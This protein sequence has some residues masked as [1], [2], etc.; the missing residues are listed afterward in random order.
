MHQAFFHS[1][2][3]REKVR[4]VPVF[5][6][7]KSFFVEICRLSDRERKM[8]KNDQNQSGFQVSSNAFKENLKQTFLKCKKKCT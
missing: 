1:F 4:N 6:R 7:P 2:A 8:N 5:M 3:K